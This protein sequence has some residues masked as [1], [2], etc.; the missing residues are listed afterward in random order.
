MKQYTYN[1]DLTREIGAHWN[2]RVWLIT[3]E[4]G[5]GDIQIS[6]IL[7]ILKE[8]DKNNDFYDDIIL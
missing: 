7:E 1:F 8:K 5:K 3:Y 2:G 4:F 6:Q